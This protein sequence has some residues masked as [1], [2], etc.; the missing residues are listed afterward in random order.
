MPLFLY[1]PLLTLDPLNTRLFH[2]P[3]P[4]PHPPSLASGAGGC[5]PQGAGGLG[6]PQ[7]RPPGAR[8]A[9]GRPGEPRGGLAA[10]PPAGPGEEDVLGLGGEPAGQAAPA[11]L[12]GQEARG[13]PGAKTFSPRTIFQTLPETLLPRPPWWPPPCGPPAWT[14]APGRAR[15]SRTGGPRPSWRCRPRPPR[16]RGPRGEAGPPTLAPG[17]PRAAGEASGAGAGPRGDEGGPPRPTAV[18]GALRPRL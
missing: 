18:T 16:T 3:C 12:Q 2:F 6:G 13:G 4:P 1:L 7:A 15:S 17:G 10:G 5:A 8:G 14:L 11:A 9:Q